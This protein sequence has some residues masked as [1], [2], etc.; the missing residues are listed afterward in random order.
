MTAN[1]WGQYDWSLRDGRSLSAR[2]DYTWTDDYTR[3]AG[4]PLQR[5]QKAYGLLNARLVYDTGELAAR[6]GRDQPHRGVLHP[7]VLLHGVA[8]DVGWQRWPAARGLPRSELRL[9]LIASM[10]ALAR[11]EGRFLLR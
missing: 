8:A 11:R 6:R 7:G 5:T 4:G 9:Q 2:L 10:L 3:F 1:L